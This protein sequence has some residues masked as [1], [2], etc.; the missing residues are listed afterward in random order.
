MCSENI[1]RIYECQVF[2]RKKWEKWEKFARLLMALYIFANFKIYFFKNL[3]KVWDFFRDDN[4]FYNWGFEPLVSVY[5]IL[6][7]KSP[8]NFKIKIPKNISTQIIFVHINQLK[9]S[10]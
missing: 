2:M 7:F 4:Y 3:Q 5:K 8:Y 10:V 6:N 9:P 1:H